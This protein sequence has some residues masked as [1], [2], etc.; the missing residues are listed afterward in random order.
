MATELGV[1][2]LS[3]SASTK[4]FARDVK[5]ALGDVEAQADGAGKSVGSRLGSGI[6]TGLKVVGGAVA[7]VAALVAG[8]AIHGGISR[9]LAI[10][11]AQAKLKGLGHSVESVQTIMD[12]ALASVKGTAFGLGDAATVAASVV[13]A[14]V[15]PG[16]ALTRTLKLVADASTIAG[17]SMSDMGLIFNKVASTGKI[18]GEVIAQLGERGIP[19]LQ[20]LGEE[21]GISAAE[22]SKL[23]AKGKI[24]FETFQAAM[25][26]G[27][28]G[29]ALESG[30]T[31][32][33]AMANTMAALGRLGEK[34][35]GGILPQ[36]KGGFGGAI[37]ALDSWAPHAEKVGAAV[38]TAL[39][40]SVAFI[41]TEVI[42]RLQAF[43]EW[44]ASEGLPRIQSF[45]GWLNTNLMPTLSTLG[46]W[47]AGPG[48]A[49]LRDFGGWMRDNVLPVLKDVGNWIANDM[50]PTL[51]SMVDWLRQNATAAKVIASVIGTLLLPILVSLGVKAV[52]SGAQQVGAWVAA[53]IASVKSTA[54]QIA[55][56]YKIV[57]GWVMSAAAAVKSG[58]QTVAIWAM[59][60]GAAIRSGA[61][62]VAVW[63][64]YRIEAA[65]AVAATLAAHARMA[66]SWVASS[67]RTVA[68]VVAQNAAMVASRAVLIAGAAA[69]GIVT[70]AQWAWNAALMANPIGLIIAAIVALV[71]GLVWFF[72][73]TEIGQKIWAGFTAFLGQAW[74]TIKTAFA[75]GREAISTFL[76]QAWEFI[77]KVWSY[78][79]I[80]LIVTNWDAIVAFFRSIPEKVRAQVDRAIEFVKT[81]FSYTPLGMLINNWDQVVAFFKGIPGKVVDALGNL[82]KTLFH[83][84]KDMIQGLIDGAGSLLKKLGQFMLD[85]LPGWIVGPFK[86]A[87]GISSPSKVF[88]GYGENLVEGLMG[89]V[90]SERGNLDKQMSNLVRPPALPGRL[91]VNVNPELRSGQGG[92][93]GQ[94]VQ[95]IHPAPGMSEQQIGAASARQIEWAMAGGPQ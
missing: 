48:L 61:Q 23:A 40:A 44:F 66:A 19:I 50:I 82:G 34:V 1:A 88:A 59:M 68:A 60:A 30:N 15:K 65:K 7:G 53:R 90:S 89:G 93:G 17:T 33:G 36:I 6:G 92:L 51:S 38:G 54:T 41:Q 29:A 71:A 69:T 76:G 85:K 2:Y 26:A 91:P 28:G 22:V 18:Q 20:L 16:E 55:S 27:M 77:K 57:A 4:D 67:A 75:A 52:V 25:E 73:Q 14:G 5:K 13:A 31:F 83:S 21:L 81:A 63:A 94:I 95:H 32:R 45:V 86:M 46:A 72:T 58:A 79:P 35:V 64:L 56:H 43:G 9:A 8:M 74:E 12:S 84:G 62:T 24:G 80:G 47:L 37:A 39:T 10:E 87:M 49:A 42:P 70:A 3:L 78:S 11:D